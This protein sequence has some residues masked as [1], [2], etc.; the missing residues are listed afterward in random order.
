MSQVA[1][2]FAVYPALYEV[3]DVTDLLSEYAGNCSNTSELSNWLNSAR[4]TVYSDRLQEALKN[5]R[6]A[7]I[8]LEWVSAVQKGL[9]CF[10]EAHNED[11]FR[12]SE[13]LLAEALEPLAEFMDQLLPTGDTFAAPSHPTRRASWSRPRASD[14]SSEPQSNA[15]TP[16]S[17]PRSGFG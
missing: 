12:E 1:A 4:H 17:R 11:D 3:Q 15:S 7:A 10:V 8:D 9:Q 14:R 13:W 2:L 5:E 16:G 6:I